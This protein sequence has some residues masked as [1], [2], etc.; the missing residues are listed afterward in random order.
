MNTSEG[1]SVC[2]KREEEEKGEAAIVGRE[3]HSSLET[4]EIVPS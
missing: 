1:L 3:H 4:F 2:R